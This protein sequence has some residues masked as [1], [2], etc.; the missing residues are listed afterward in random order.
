MARG[1]A[2]MAVLLLVPA[3]AVAAPRYTAP[4][5]Q[6]TG[7]CESD[8]PCPIATAFSSANANDEVIL[9]T[10]DYGSVDVPYTTQL[11]SAEPGL[12]V[13]GEAGKPRP[14]IFFERAGNDSSAFVLSG[15]GATL[16]HLEV[17]QSAAAG[18]RTGLLVLDN[19][20]ATDVVARNAGDGGRACV[21]LHASELTDALCEATQID[22]YGVATFTG[23]GPGLANTSVL[24]NVTAIA[25]AAGSHGIFAFAG[26]ST[27]DG[28]HLTVSNTIARG[29][30]THADVEVGTQSSTDVGDITIDHSNFG[31]E[32]WNPSHGGDRVLDNASSGNQRSGGVV[33]AAAGDYHQAP[34]SITIDAGANSALNGPVDFD[35]DPRALGGGTDIGA[36]EFVPPPTVV[37]LPADGV[38]RSAAVLHG[39]VNPNTVA[40][41]YHFEYGRTTAYGKR[42]PEIAAGGGNAT[43]GVS[44]TLKGLTSNVTYHFRLVAKSRGGT[45]GGGD[46]TFKTILAKLL[47]LTIAPEEFAA[48][49]SGGSVGAAAAKPPV[50]TTVTFKLNK[51]AGVRFGVKRQRP[52]RRVNG[53][54]V[55]PTTSNRSA[56]KC[57]R[58]VSVKGGFKVA[59]TA[60]KNHFRFTGRLGGKALPEGRYRLVGKT[61]GNKKQAAFR[62]VPR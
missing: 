41:T 28:Q 60:G 18:L 52:G 38:T 56:P 59:G 19:A 5:A 12:D 16:H 4:D 36:D 49:A 62:I 9:R 14:R 48:A 45:V 30:P 58:F 53:H 44:A 40:T 32:G 43:R 31:F 35:G 37:T 50:G 46:L 34:N 42:T 26:T 47:S 21:V 27:A 57:K 7:T 6:V 8:S 10:G 54:C 24:R 23:V 20:H 2:V 29:V 55:T 15:Q 39:T 11:G 61:A 17:R 51:A 3:T 22:S 1:L 25:Q 13:H 33:F